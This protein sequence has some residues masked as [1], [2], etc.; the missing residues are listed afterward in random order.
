MG[1]VAVGNTPAVVQAPGEDGASRRI[2]G[3]AVG[4]E[5]KLQYEGVT[6][7]GGCRREEKSRKHWSLSTMLLTSVTK[8]FPFFC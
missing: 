3:E 8:I 5:M 2:I 1:E 7:N 6:S 4:V